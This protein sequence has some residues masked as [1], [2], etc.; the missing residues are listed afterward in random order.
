M[1]RTDDGGQGRARKGF[2]VEGKRL[3]KGRPSG[4]PSESVERKLRILLELVRNKFVTVSRLCE[5]YETS[6]RSL[7]RDFQELRR[8]G[9][10]A[11]FK[12]SD[13]IENDQIRLISFDTRPTALAKS[14]RALQTLIHDAAQAFGPPVEQQLETIAGEETSE[15]RF[16]RFLLPKLR[17][18]TRVADVYKQLEAA[19][20]AN[21][22][23]SFMYSGR[24]RVVEPGVVVHRSGRYYLVARDPKS[25]DWKYFALDKIEGKITRAGSFS[26]QPV[27]ERYTSG[28]VIGFMKGK[29]EHR[30]SVWIGASIAASATSREWQPEQEVVMHEDGSATIT[31]TVSEIDEVIR[32]ALG[33]GAEARVCAPDEAVAAARE[34]A[35][36]IARSYDA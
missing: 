18:G 3:G 24:E 28:N 32:W 31:F 13:R 23:V 30:V 27:P 17:E 15:Q 7:I 9:E 10:H 34:M 6:E 22:R 21:A 19:W 36:R 35:Q 16:L 11:G 12:L 20:S 33:F 29:G 8:I 4:T 1:S 5:E 26:P 14:G 25:R 2:P